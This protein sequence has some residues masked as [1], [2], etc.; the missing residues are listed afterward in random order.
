MPESGFRHRYTVMLGFPSDLEPRAWV[1]PAALIFCRAAP[2]DGCSHAGIRRFHRPCRSGLPSGSPELSRPGL[3]L[4]GL[5]DREKTL[6]H[7]AIAIMRCLGS[8]TLLLAEKMPG[9][10]YSIQ[11]HNMHLHCGTIGHPGQGMPPVQEP[12]LCVLN[13]IPNLF[14]ALIIAYFPAGEHGESITTKENFPACSIAPS[15]C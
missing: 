13:Q 10:A 2:V 6:Y 14:D 9:G 4:A 8:R 12:D 7:R 1:Q 11:A 5:L 3:L 15:S